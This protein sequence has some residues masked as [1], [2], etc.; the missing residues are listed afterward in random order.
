MLIITVVV[1]LLVTGQYPVLDDVENNLNL[2]YNTSPNK[3]ETSPS[4]QH[5][6]CLSINLHKY[7]S[8]FV[9]ISLMG[10]YNYEPLEPVMKV[11][12]DSY[13]LVHIVKEPT[14]FK[15]T[16][17]PRCIDLII[18]NRKTHVVLILLS[19]IGKSTLY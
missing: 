3:N 12:C 8:S 9:N 6:N 10:D 19:R 18:T 11:L 14:C 16:E 17:N 13:N 7:S 4:A 15:N 1:S 5:F 2:L